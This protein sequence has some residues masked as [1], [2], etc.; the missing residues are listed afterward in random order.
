MGI[1]RVG[2]YCC[3]DLFDITFKTE[4]SILKHPK[5]TSCEYNEAVSLSVVAIGA[6]QLKYQWRRN[7]QDINDPK[8]IGVDTSNLG[9]T[10]VSDVHI[11]KY[12][13]I[14]EDSQMSVESKPAQLDLGKLKQ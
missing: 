10:S 14:V 6:G 8:C 13:C 7:E 9:I 11:G 1:A 4:L 2:G 12:T 3:S 5:S